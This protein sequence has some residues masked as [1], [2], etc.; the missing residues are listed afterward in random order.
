MKKPL[1]TLLLGCAISALQAQR[2]SL[3]RDINPGAASSN[4]CYLTKINNQL[5]FGAN[6]G[7]HGMEL[8]KSDGTPTGTVMIKDIFPGSG[9]SSIGYIT[10][11][12]SQVYF[13]ASNG[14]NGVELWKSDGS[15]DGTTMV[16]DIRTGSASSF[17]SALAALGN[18]VLFSATDGINGAELWKSDGTTAGTTMLKDIYSGGAS[19]PQYLVNM[20]GVI[21]F[22]ADNGINGRELWKTDGTTAGT[23]MVKDIY[24]GNNSSSPTSLTVIG[25]TLF[26]AASNGTNGT[27][28]WKS[29]GTAAGTVMVKDI[30][31]GGSESYPFNLRNVAGTLYFSADN[32]ANGMELWKSD[33]TA[34]GTVLVK[35]VWPG[36][37]SGANGNF[38]SIVNQLVFTG[39]DGVNGD[40]NWQSDGTGT[41]TQISRI[42]IDAGAG[43]IREVQET[44]FKIYA[45]VQET[46]LGRELYA[47]DFSVI[48]PLVWLK[49]EGKLQQQNALLSWK[50]VQEEN[51]ENF[52]V[53]RSTNGRDFTA[54]GRV[55]AANSPGTHSYSFTD[56][57]VLSVGAPVLYYRLRQNDLFG[58]FD[59]SAVITINCRIDS[60]VQ[61]FPVPATDKVWVTGDFRSSNKISYQVF[62][63]SGKQVL[64]ASGVSVN[65]GRMEVSVAALAP[66]IYYLRIQEEHTDKRLRIVKR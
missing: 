30:W 38:A 62:D 31:N 18:T 49:F 9:S 65:A 4:V 47:L 57:D 63:N 25:S 42:T 55:S 12:G 35:D 16:R 21:Y 19:S 60:D 50:T 61:L 46:T 10:A 58:R 7:T 22:S 43:T 5:F 44:D 13:V 6:N 37:P 28:L 27:E 24:A 1:F 36:S 32:G 29:D 52:V 53:E 40:Q 26:F 3:I 45:S 20:N 17:P 14:P 2:F 8:W 64:Q 56:E 54:V 59:Y 39:N 15:A 48:L 33:G 11:V 41:G 23:V 66:G 34:A 51:T